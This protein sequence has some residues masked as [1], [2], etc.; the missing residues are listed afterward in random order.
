MSW[1]IFLLFFNLIILGHEFG[2]FFTAKKSGVKIE[3]FGLGFP[4]R[5]FGLYKE[6][7]KFKF[8]FGP[9][10]IKTKKTIYSLN[11]LPFGGFN[12]IFGE[13]SSVKEKGSLSAAGFSKKVL[14][15]S[16][17]VLMNIL[18]AWFAFSM[19][20]FFGK[21]V[22]IS[23][24]ESSANLAKSKVQIIDIAPHS[25]ASK[26]L[27]IGDNILAM[28]ISGKDQWFSVKT[29][30]DLVDFVNSHKGDSFDL[31]IERQNK[32]VI[33]KINSRKNPPKGEGSIG[34]ALAS[35]GIKKLPLISSFWQAAKDVYYMTIFIVFSLFKV[36][37]QLIATGKTSGNIGGP[38]KIV[39]L[40]SQMAKL[41]FGYLIFFIGTLSLDLAILNFLPFPALD[42]GRLMLLFIEKIIKKPIPEKI[43]RGINTFGF[44]ALFLLMILVTIKDVKSLF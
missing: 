36:I 34:V 21:P 28:R 33:E 3:E 9:K 18:I 19:A 26:N 16:A 24:Q 37:Q 17:G 39:V 30:K 4:P 42:G 1:L 15:I 13:D 8:I 14:I 6:N 7:G 20:Y 2:H 23:S 38:V 32:V 40:G 44:I 27:N 5:I 12:K 31:K 22:S 29:V 41:S 25:P 43:E 35:V 10:E 11:L